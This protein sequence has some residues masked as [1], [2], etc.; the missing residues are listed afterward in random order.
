MELG[1]LQLGSALGRASNGGAGG[2]GFGGGHNNG[3]NNNGNNNNGGRKQFP[4]RSFVNTGTCSFGDRCKF[5]HDAEERAKEPALP[6]WAMPGV[7]PEG[8]A[9]HLRRGALA[10]VREALERGSE[11]NITAVVMGLDWPRR[12][13]PGA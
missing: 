2:G 6:P 7:K 11:D 8:E 12:G 3:F 5:P 1:L 9:A 4:C 10:V 13:Q